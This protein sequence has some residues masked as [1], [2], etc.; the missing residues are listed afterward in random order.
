MKVMT[1]INVAKELTQL[2]EA[3]GDALFDEIEQAYREMPFDSE[4]RFGLPAGIK[5]TGTDRAATAQLPQPVYSYFRST[6][7]DSPWGNECPGEIEWRVEAPSIF[8]WV[9]AEYDESGL[10]DDVME[11]SDDA[12]ALVLKLRERLSLSH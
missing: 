4:K 11:F 9:L 6:W 12:A 7:G 8:V 5:I 1:E 3:K 2:F 10:V